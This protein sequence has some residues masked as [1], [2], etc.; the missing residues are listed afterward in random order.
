MPSFADC[1]KE[2]VQRRKV[3]PSQADR[4]KKIIAANSEDSEAVEFLERFIQKTAE[5][6]RVNEIQVLAYRR[7]R[8]AALSH[9]DG[10]ERGVES[11]L[12]RDPGDR[13]GNIS[14]VDYRSRAIYDK[15]RAMAADA[16]D[17][18][19]VRRLGLVSDDELAQRVGRAMFGQA[20]DPEA[21]RLAKELTSAL[22]MV[23]QRGNV[24]GKHIER[25]RDFGLPQTHDVRRIASS[26]AD[27]W[28]DFTLPLVRRVYSEGGPIESP[29]YIRK[30]LE[31]M[32]DEA[33]NSAAVLESGVAGSIKLESESRR[34]VFN[35]YDAWE[36][37]SRRFGHGEK[38]LLNIVDDH[39]RGAS[40]ELGLLEILGP[41][42]RQT[43][44]QLIDEAAKQGALTAWQR[45][46]IDRLYSVVS[47]QADW[48][49]SQW[50]ANTGAFI[51]SWLVSAQLGGAVLS[52]FNDVITA[53]AARIANDM[54]LTRA[55]DGALRSMTKAEAARLGIA[56]DSAIVGLQSAKFGELAGAAGGAG[57]AADLVLRASGLTQWTEA[58]RRAFGV[59]LLAHLGDQVGAKTK[60]AALSEGLR[61]SLGKYGITAETWDNIVL[62]TATIDK[63]GANFLDLDGFGALV[64]K[65]DPGKPFKDAAEQVE[66]EQL[67]RGNRKGA[68]SKRMAEQYRKA[69]EVQDKLVLIRDTE[70]RL[71]ELVATESEF[72]MLSG[73]DARVK[74]V[75]T[76]GAER[77]SL[78]GELARTG[79]LYKSFPL[80]IAF[81]QLGRGLAQPTVGGKIGYL[82]AF[83][84][85]STV[86]AALSLQ[87]KEV[88]KG[89]G[90]RPMD[91]L[92][93]WVDSVGQGG[94][95]SVFDALL[96]ADSGFERVARQLAGPAPA[97]IESAFNL[98]VGNLFQLGKGEDTHA[99]RELT[100]FAERHTPGSN[101]WYS[102]LMVQRWFWDNMLRLLDDD[103]GQTFRRSEAAAKRWGA[104]EY[105][106]RPGDVVP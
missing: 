33:K 22:D 5:T 34:I 85:A 26:T 76:W 24:A 95:L 27:E 97:M 106:W 23:R 98:T 21:T 48:V 18:L 9:P 92:G 40:R 51:R 96:E 29:V 102:R 37:Y 19:G 13:A 50:L 6:K 83:A 45:G 66:A 49:K 101:I 44:D 90:L 78:V 91:A 1:L 103:A 82:T 11:L 39:L 52:S 15:A 4:I 41:R 62:Q 94:A 87:A 53:S 2:A 68:L 99:G 70:N 16:F 42:P 74:A 12:A 67:L 64:K 93:F 71:R 104:G 36:Q 32:Y 28:I 81:Y 14:N 80:S 31:A 38:S 46:R 73:S 105:W 72:A 35:G 10:I 75:T 63:E 47:G 65:L 88:V 7:A 54:P 55:F 61:K 17:K 20:S 30:W 57:K 43:L 3:T 69:V 79:M 89:R 25:R 100:K 60:F 84:G 59:E 56:A 86:V 58:G 77:G 8:A